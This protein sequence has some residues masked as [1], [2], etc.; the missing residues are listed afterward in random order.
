MS[1]EDARNVG[2]TIRTL[3]FESSYKLPQR[4][5][6]HKQT[7]F[8]KEEREGLRE[9]LTGVEEIDMLEINFDSALRYVASIQMQ[10]GTFDEDNYPVRRGTAVQLDAFSSL[11][12][13]HGVTEAVKKGLRY[14][15]GKRRIPTPLIVR[16]HAGSSDIAQIATEILALSKMDWNSADMYS[17]LPVTIQSSQKIARIGS[18]L[19]RFGPTSYDYRLFI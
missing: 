7:A 1:Q 2:E 9:G 6:I 12:W 18:L 13:V 17:K 4:V 5:V 10:N 16:R 19:Q 8:R 14:Y 11:V 15:K 3:F